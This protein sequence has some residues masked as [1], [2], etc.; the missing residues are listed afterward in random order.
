MSTNNYVTSNSE[1]VNFNQTY[2][3]YDQT[4]APSSTNSVD[5][6]GPPFTPGTVMAGTGDSEFVF[7]KASANIA[8]GAVVQI[9]TATFAATGITTSN[10]LLGNLVGVAQVAIASGQYGWVQR[11]GRCD[12][13]S[14]AA[15]CNPNVQL[16][17]TGTAG[18]LDDTVTGGPVLINGIIITAATTPAAAVAGTLNNPVVGVTST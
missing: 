12:N 11:M 1:G 18:V 16:A 4:V 13:I 3:A 5:N 8:I 17:T 14:V 6:P 15:G 9:T 10:A 7:V 2:S